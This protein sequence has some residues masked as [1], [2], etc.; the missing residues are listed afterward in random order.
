M[1]V[2]GCQPYA[3]AAFTPRINLVL[4]F[5]DWV[6]PRAHGMN[7]WVIRVMHL[8]LVDRPFVPQIGILPSFISRGTPHHAAGETSISEGRKL[9]IQIL[10]AARNEQLLGSF[11]CPKVGTWDR[12]FDFP[13]E[14]RHAEDF[15]IRK[16]RRLR[17]GLNTRTREPEASMLTTRPPKLPGTWNC[18]M[19]RKKEQG[20]TGN[21]CR[22]L[23]TCSAVP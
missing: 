10:P 6:D 13:P 4:I 17:P 15:Y 16:I 1:N 3:P 18:Q 14:G 23:P 21:R 19:P 2:V 7:E 20:D 11:T 9:N 12:L 22:D 8:G 5:R